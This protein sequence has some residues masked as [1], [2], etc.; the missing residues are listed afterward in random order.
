MKRFGLPKDNLLRKSREFARVYR[1]GRRLQ[2]AGFSLIVLANN[3]A[4]SRLGISVHRMVRGAVRRNRIKRMF[5][6]V[7]RLRRDEF[8]GFC[9]I[10]VTVRPDFACPA[11]S[12]LQAAV[13]AALARI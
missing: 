7:F 10:V 1:E 2:G 9:D 8:P 4:S 11:T 3:L 5:R 12:L 13:R 6:E